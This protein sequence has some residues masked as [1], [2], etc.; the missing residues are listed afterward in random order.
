MHT[1]DQMNQ[2]TMVFPPAVECKHTS[3]RVTVAR[4]VQRKML[5]LRHIRQELLQSGISENAVSRECCGVAHSEIT[6]RISSRLLKTA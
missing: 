2:L 6:N 1:S 4:R 3:S 5:E